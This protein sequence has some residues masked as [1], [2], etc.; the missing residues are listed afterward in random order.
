MLNRDVG[1]QYTEKN[2]N[3][4]YQITNLPYKSIRI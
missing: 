4:E 2:M 1:I 3:I